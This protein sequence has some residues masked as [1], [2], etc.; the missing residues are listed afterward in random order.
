[1]IYIYFH[2]VRFLIQKNFCFSYIE[3]TVIQFLF[4]TP[5]QPKPKHLVYF[6]LARVVFIPL[7][8]VCKYYPK[9][10]DRVMPVYID[11][12]WVYWIIAILMSFTSGY[13]R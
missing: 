8:L 13:L 2:L 3:F 10:V 7:F 12:N 5:F 1:M 4:L 6:A 11:S 9:D